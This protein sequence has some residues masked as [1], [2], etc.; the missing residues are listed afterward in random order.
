VLTVSPEFKEAVGSPARTTGFEVSFGIFD[1]TA[2]ADANIEVSQKQTFVQENQ[3]IDEIRTCPCFANLGRNYWL[4]NGEFTS[5][6]STVSVPVGYY[7]QE[8]SNANGAFQE[9]PVITFLFTE[10]HSSV[11]LTLFFDMAAGDC[12]SDFKVEW[13]DENGTLMD[14]A[15]VEGNEDT[16]CRLDR[17]VENYYKVVL[18]L[19]KTALPYRYARLTE[20]DF[21]REEVYTNNELISAQVIEEIDPAASEIPS[22]VLTFT[23]DNLSGKFN[24]INPTGIYQYLQGRQKLEARSIVQTVTGTESVPMGVFYLKEWANPNGILAK[25]KA[26][27]FID[28]LG[29]STYEE[30]LYSN[31]SLGT[32]LSDLFSHGG[33]SNYQIDPALSGQLLNGYLAE[34]T[35]REALHTIAMAV[36]AVVWVN[37]EGVIMIKALSDADSV[38][39]INFDLLLGKPEMSLRSLVNGVQVS[40]YTTTLVDGR[41]EHSESKVTVQSPSRLANEPGQLATVSGNYLIS[42]EA[43][44]VAIGQRVLDYYGKRYA[45]A[46]SWWADPS[47]EPGDFVNISTQYGNVLKSRIIKTTWDFKGGTKA[48]S[49]AVG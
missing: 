6:P 13:F 23:V 4:L 28:L 3:I 32:A 37:R 25:L 26:Y 48:K 40:W 20:V 12:C 39:D 2:K 35:Y 11:G 15:E 34:D 19:Q 38:A 43:L 17:M 45:Q 42:S 27:D 47:I 29:Q 49:E 16:K 21:G 1:V 10:P 36:G 9:A 5:F 46:L 7:S 41:Y 8:L 14:T 33:I 31:V 18:A 30:K 22:N 44:A 24:M